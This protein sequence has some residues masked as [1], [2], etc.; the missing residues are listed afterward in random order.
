[1]TQSPKSRSLTT[2]FFEAL[3]RENP[4]P[5]QFATSEY[6]AQKYATTLAALPR[7]RYESGFEIGGSIGIMTEQLA[8][9][10]DRLLSI[11]VSKIAQSQAIQ[12][13][14]HLNHIDFQLMSV[15]NEF[16]ADAFDLLVLSEVGYYWSWDDLHKAQNL[17][18]DRLQPQGHLLLVHWIVDARVLPLTGDEVHDSFLELV[19][20]RF[21]HIHSL[22]TD[23]YRLDLLEK[24]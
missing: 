2:D 13:C 5:W 4:D 1:M 20:D 22:T 19:P 11:D 6:E 24:V 3:Y 18:F 17:I 9:R 7:D 16:P 21:K 23:K 15:P 10:C 14:Q 8:Q 12:R